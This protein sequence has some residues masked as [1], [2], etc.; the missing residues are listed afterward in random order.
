MLNSPPK[1]LA[2]LTADI[3]LLIKYGAPEEEFANLCE[4]M[5][6]YDADA[7]ALNVFHNFYSYLPEAEDDGIIKIS[8][9]AHR[10]GAFL[11]YVATILSD[12]LYLATR[13]SASLIGPFKTTVLDQELLDFFGWPDE[14]H[15]RK[16]VGAPAGLAKH[17]PV[18]ASVEL[19]PACGTNDGDIHAFGCPVEVCPWCDGQL[20]SCGCRF[21]KTGRESFSQD[22]H[23]D[24]LLDLLTEK[25]RVPFAAAQH[26]PSF[27]TEADLADKD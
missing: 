15:F 16:E 7:I 21:S 24:E 3:S 14:A 23:L 13:E 27:L 18:N 17:V 26:R 1:T 19:C 9:I 25:G 10:H 8:R 11:F 4:V 6:E 2:A 5:G 12:Y 20:T 22:S